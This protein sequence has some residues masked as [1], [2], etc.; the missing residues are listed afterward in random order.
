MSTVGWAACGGLG[1]LDPPVPAAGGAGPPGSWPGRMYARRFA[2]VPDHGHDSEEVNLRACHEGSACVP[3]RLRCGRRASGGGA[4]DAA[5]V[6]DFVRSHGAH[7]TARGSGS[8]GLWH[9]YKPNLSR[10]NGAYSSDPALK[11]RPTHRLLGPDVLIYEGCVVRLQEDDHPRDGAN[12]NE[13]IALLFV[14]SGA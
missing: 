12:A 13:R 7:S 5:A 3:A 14:P 10:Q 9:R 6:Q 8:S 11:L 4:V 2:P 1:S